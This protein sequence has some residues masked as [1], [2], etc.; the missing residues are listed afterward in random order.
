MR[1]LPTIFLMVFF[2]LF[3]SACDGGG[4]SEPLPY[5]EDSSESISSSVA[6]SAESS[7]EKGSLMAES[8]SSAEN[9]SSETPTN[10]S[11]SIVDSSSAGQSSSSVFGSSSSMALYVSFGTM[12]DER[13][14]LTYKTVTINSQTWMAENLNYAYLQPTSFLDSSSWCYGDNSEN[15]EKYGR[16]YLWSAAMDSAALFSED[17]AECGYFSAGETWRRCPNGDEKVQGICPEGWHLPTY[18]EYLSSLPLLWV[19]FEDDEET[20]FANGFFD[21]ETGKFRY[22]RSKIAFWLSKEID[23]EKAYHDGYNPSSLA[24]SEGGSL[25]DAVDASDKRNAFPVRCVKD[26]PE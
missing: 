11:S 1:K 18:D 26:N 16:L 17:G 4:S 7:S 22:D 23:N 12:T 8:S 6:S 21:S 10:S 24:Y 13:D 25:C 14:G 15:C 3:L 2:L 9:S 19:Y 5:P 20:F